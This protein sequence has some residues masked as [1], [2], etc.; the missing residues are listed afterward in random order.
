MS[1]RARRSR[2]VAGLLFLGVAGALSS[3][4]LPGRVALAPASV[5]ATWF[6]ISHLV[7]ATIGYQG[8]PELGAIPSVMLDR[9]V[10]TRCELWRRIDHLLGVAVIMYV[11]S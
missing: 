4:R 7:A 2:I 11:R 3:R 1:P 9:P 5:V 8:C 10:A 6:G